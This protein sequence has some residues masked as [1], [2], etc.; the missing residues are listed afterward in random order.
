[1]RNGIVHF[2]AGAEEIKDSARDRKASPASKAFNES[3]PRR[4]R[5]PHHLMYLV[6]PRYTRIINRRPCCNLYIHDT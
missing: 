4:L 6:L 2:F 1:M 3:R 5:R